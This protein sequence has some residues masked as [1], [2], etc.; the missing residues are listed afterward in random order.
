MSSDSVPNEGTHHREWTPTSVRI[1]SI[2]CIREKLVQRE[3]G[4]GYEDGAEIDVVG[5]GTLVVLETPT[6]IKAA[7]A[8]S[9][10]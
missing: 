2:A 4:M 1:A 9:E 10:A 6:R 3:R 8:R 7:I 5:L